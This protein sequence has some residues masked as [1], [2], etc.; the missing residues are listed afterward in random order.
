MVSE[1]DPSI[2]RFDYG[3][4]FVCVRVDRGERYL[5]NHNLG[6]SGVTTAKA[7][8]QNQDSIVA[9]PL[10]AS[11]MT[12]AKAICQYQDSITSMGASGGT[13]AKATHHD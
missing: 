7:T 10:E 3:T 9:S 1:S 5:H 2:S 13:T 11:I 12:T 8:C 4:C 6:V